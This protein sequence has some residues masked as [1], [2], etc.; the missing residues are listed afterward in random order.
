MPASA[1]WASPDVDHPVRYILEFDSAAEL[2]A[3]AAVIE[4]GHAEVGANVPVIVVANARAQTVKL[5]GTAG[6]HEG[7]PSLVLELNERTLED[8][9]HVASIGPGESRVVWDPRSGDG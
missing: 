2:S 4:A 9:P 7:R 8:G 5:K 6:E 1:R 3:A